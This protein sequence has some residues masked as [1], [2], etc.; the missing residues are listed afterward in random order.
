MKNGAYGGSAYSMAHL[1]KNRATG[2]E[3]E[4]DI[5]RMDWAGWYG[6]RNRGSI[7]PLI[8]GLHSLARSLQQWAME[9]K[10]V[11]ICHLDIHLRPYIKINHDA[12]GAMSVCD[13]RIHQDH[14]GGSFLSS[15]VVLCDQLH[16]STIIVTIC[17]DGRLVENRSATK[18]RRLTQLRAESLCEISL[19]M[20]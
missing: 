8:G 1:R 3:S 13:V 16:H 15:V 14:L 9:R 19:L 7:D 20:I 6:T 12:R 17:M 4:L 11:C 2:M 5:P 18:R 10:G